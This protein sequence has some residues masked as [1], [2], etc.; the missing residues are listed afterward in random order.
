MPQMNEK[1]VRDSGLIFALIFLL[2]GYRGSSLFLALSILVLLALLFIPK[3]LWPFAYLW[4]KLAEALAFVMNRVFFGIIFF[5]II[6][7]IG[8][9]R[10]VFYGDSRYLVLNKARTSGFVDRGGIVTR[11]QI[12]KPY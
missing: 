3:L 8:Y 7:P 2:L 12:E 11:A 9:L 10:R 1:W 4:L 5:L 6:T